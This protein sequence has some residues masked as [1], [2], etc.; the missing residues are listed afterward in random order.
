M[1]FFKRHI[2]DYHKKAGRLTMLEHG[3]YTLL[4][5]A[6]YD[7]ERFPTREDALDWCWA[8]SPEEIAAVEFVLSKFFTPDEGVFKQARIQ[9]EIEA[10]RAQAEKNREI[11]LLREETRRQRRANN[12]NDAPPYEHEACT[13]RADTQDEGS[14]NRAPVQHESPPNHKPLTTNQEPRTNT[15]SLRSEEGESDAA[16]PPPPPL[17]QATPATETKKAKVEKSTAAKPDDVTDQTWA[18]WLALRKAKKAPPTETVLALARREAEKAKLPLEDFLQIW[19]ARGSQGLQADWLKPHEL[20]GR[21]VNSSAAR[22]PER[23]HQ[24][25]DYGPAGARRL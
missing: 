22:H 21:D 18:D 9:E 10:Y 12:A 25:Q 11:A 6:C 15:S 8:R 7:R 14:T 23:I 17:A 2:G 13:K 16:A 19:C 4:M 24:P 3:A 1:N 5:D 20:A